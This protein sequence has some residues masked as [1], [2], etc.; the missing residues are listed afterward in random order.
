MQIRTRQVQPLDFSHAESGTG[1]ALDRC[2]QRNNKGTTMTTT[3][4]TMSNLT[5]IET[6]HQ[7]ISP[8]ARM[9]ETIGLL[10]QGISADEIGQ[11]LMRSEWTRLDLSIAERLHRREI[12]RAETASYLAR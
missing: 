11:T 6:Y 12:E 8:A 10:G 7:E 3:E 1:Y 2:I 9:A 5:K 4:I